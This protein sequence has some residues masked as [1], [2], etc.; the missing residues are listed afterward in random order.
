MDPRLKNNLQQLPTN[1]STW[2]LAAWG[3]L[4]AI[5][6]A[7]TPEQQQ[8][9]KT[10]VY[11]LAPWLE[12]WMGIIV[13]IV[14]TLIGRAWPQNRGVQTPAPAANAADPLEPPRED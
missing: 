13:V 1:I 4:A 14:T 9:I 2:V 6:F 8:Q 11:G 5:W 10:A 3:A 7:L 12:A